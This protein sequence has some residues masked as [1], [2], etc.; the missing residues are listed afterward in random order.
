MRRNPKMMSAAASIAFAPAVEFGPKRSLETLSALADHL[1]QMNP[2]DQAVPGLFVE[3]ISFALDHFFPVQNGSR[4]FNRSL[5]FEKAQGHPDLHHD[6][7]AYFQHFVWTRPADTQTLGQNNAD[8]WHAMQF[9]EY[10]S[11]YDVDL[12][13]DLVAITVE[14]CENEDG[15]DF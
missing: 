11:I 14:P 4:K 13:E 12:P 2:T 15:P 8:L 5:N 3:D 1:K 9:A 7:M 10:V 6:T